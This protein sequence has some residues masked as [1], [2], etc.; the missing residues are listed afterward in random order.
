MFTSSKKKMDQ[1]STAKVLI[2]S[3]V[4]WAAPSILRTLIVIGAVALA[5]TTASCLYVN[6]L[7]ADSIKA[8]S[9]Q[10]RLI[11]LN[12]AKLKLHMAYGLM[13]DCIDSRNETDASSE[14]YC[15][16]AVELYA[17]LAADGAGR[18]NVDELMERGAHRTMQ[19]DIRYRMNINE[20]EVAKLAWSDPSG[21][22]LKRALKANTILLVVV[23]LTLLIISLYIVIL[24]ARHAIPKYAASPEA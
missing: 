4:R 7:L 9:L 6:S 17:D 20:M 16:E 19:T 3:T 10:N 12:S 21:E 1:F 15:E 8:H 13:G 18:F 5:F 24:R 23:A 2:D 22:A 14:F 11:D